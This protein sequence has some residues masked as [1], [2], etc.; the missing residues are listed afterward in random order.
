MSDIRKINSLVI[1][2]AVKRMFLESVHVIGKDIYISICDAKKNETSLIAKE[3]LDELIINYDIAKNERIPICQDTGYAV[4]FVEIGQE[5]IVVNGN[6]TNAIEEG[7]RQAYEEGYL[8]KSIVSDPIFERKN[9]NDNTPPII[10][11]T[12]V[13][14]DSIEI[15]VTAKGFGSENM[16]AIK[17]L[18]PSD[19][20]GGVKTFVLETIRTAGPN[21]CPPIIVGIG[22]GG[23]MEKAAIMAKRA[24]IREINKHN[25][26]VKYKELEEELLTKINELGIG[27]AGLG[28]KTTALA[29]NIE[30]Y[31]THIAGLPVAI[32][33][34]C[35][36][37][38]HAYIKL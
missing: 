17:M 37:A 25:E 23:T 7:V 3:I 15:T 19:G 16:S 8:R 35:H 2:D 20:V 5:V 28:G 12:I 1:T 30:Y 26:N 14:G 29:V 33:I 36:A 32:N 34:C 21:P 11:Y 31:P 9:T 10:H 4:V 6:L 22:I 38:R 27:P 13:D 24:T 18:S